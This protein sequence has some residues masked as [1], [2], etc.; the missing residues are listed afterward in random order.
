MYEWARNPY[1]ILIIIYVFGPYFSSVFIP[2]KV[3]GPATWSFMNTAAAFAI[4]LLSPFLGAIAD[5]VG[6]RK[7]W[8][9]LM[10]A[11]AIP[12]IACLWYAVP[13]APTA[14]ILAMTAVIIVVGA[15]LEYSAVF[16]NAM[17]VNVAPATRI[18]A[19][20]GLALAL[21]NVAGL[22]LLLAMLV[23][24]TGPATAGSIFNL[25]G[26]PA[27]GLDP[28]AFEHVRIAGPIVALWLALWVAP[29]LLFTPDV[30]ATGVGVRAAISQGLR[31]LW[32]TLV[33]LREF[34]N[35]ALYLFARMIYND[36]KVAILIFGGVF[37]QTTFDWSFDALILYGI[38]LSFF[39]VGGGVIGGR[40][41]DRLGS[42]PAILISIGGSALTLLVAVS[43]TRTSYLFLFD[44]DPATGFRLWDPALFPHLGSLPELLFVAVVILAAMFIT[45]AFANSRTMLA[46]IAPN[47]MMNQCFGLYALSGQATTFLATG[48]FGTFT[49]LFQSVRAG[50]ASALVFL[51]VGFVLMLW[52][53]EERAEAI[54]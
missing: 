19:L 4:A 3:Q 5:Q 11:I 38:I 16:H 36:G 49:T 29:L 39:A 37:A 9:A 25:L 31:S 24:F 10:V 22:A 35:V 20:S 18:G 8:I 44:Y 21:G 14:T 28:G 23:L 13:A 40:L 45:S 42:K 41:D 1:Y 33:G 6:R 52:V 54:D 53:R 26:A 12:G 50:F 15:T 30:P 48:A 51:V 2:D 46:R 43:I 34:R 27:L 47:E 7:P 32:R 17:L